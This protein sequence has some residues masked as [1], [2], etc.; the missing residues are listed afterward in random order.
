M[1]KRVLMVLLTVL[2][3][4][5]ALPSLALSGVPQEEFNEFIRNIREEKR[6]DRIG[7]LVLAQI[8]VSRSNDNRVLQSAGKILYA[9]ADGYLTHVNHVRLQRMEKANLKPRVLDKKRLDDHS[10]AWYMVWVPTAED[11]A[12]LTK[13]FEPILKLENTILVRIRPEDEV[14][15]GMLGLHYSLIDETLQPLRSLPIKREPARTIRVIPAIQGL[16]SQI[17]QESLQAIVQKLQD[18]KSRHVSQPG[19][20]QASLWLAEE[21][22]KIPGLEVT[23]PLFKTSAGELM[24]VVAVKKGSKDPNQ[25]YVLCGHHDSTVSSYDRKVAPGADDNASGAGAVLAIA[26]IIGS[27]DFPFTVIFA[28]MN[29]EES[30][31]LGSKA[32]VKTLAATSGLQIKAVFNMDMIGDKDDNDVAVIGNTNSNWLIDVFKDVA[33]AY[34][35]LKSTCQYNSNIWQSDHSSFWNIGAPAILTI[36]GYPEYSKYYHSV[37]DLVKNM[38]FSFMEKVT[39]SNMAALL[40]LNT[41]VFPQP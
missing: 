35:G 38:S 8:S 39:R 32:F 14:E 16:I 20:S 12:R 7:Y 21:F 25:V 26:R 19:N 17:T 10:E 18:F 11:E 27:F 5:Q 31:L 2:V 13:L 4:F 9:G 24:N 30:G 37:N 23:T 36:E 6:I 34:T 40:T 41:P 33:L 3:L 15:I 22:R 1:K 28:G 29:A